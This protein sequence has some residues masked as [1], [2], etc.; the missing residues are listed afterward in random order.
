MAGYDKELDKEVF[1]DE[2]KF[3]TTKIKVAVMS[4]NEGQPK[5]QISR[6]NLDVDSGNWR[7]SKLGRMT[8]TETEAVID[9][10]KKALDNMN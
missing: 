8:K 5:V 1:A 3:E 10:L 4:Y 7:W 6:E 9:S 2:A